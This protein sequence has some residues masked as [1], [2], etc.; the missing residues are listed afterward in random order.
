VALS[1]VPPN[2]ATEMNFATVHQCDFWDGLTGRT[3]PPD[4]DQD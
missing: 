2:P 4:N 1:L 3:L